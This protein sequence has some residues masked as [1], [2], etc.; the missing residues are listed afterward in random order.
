MEEMEGT[1]EEMEGTMEEMEG[2]SARKEME[3]YLFPQE[4]LT[5]GWLSSSPTIWAVNTILA[6]V[7][8]LGLFFLILSY[9]QKHRK[10]RKYQAEPWRRSNRRKKN[11]TLKVFRDC[12][13]DLEEVQDLFSLLQSRLARLSD[14]GGFHQFFRQA[15]P[16]PV[17]RGAPAGAR[18]PCRE[19]VEDA[20]PAVAPSPAHAPLTGPPQPLASTLPS[21]PMTSSISSGRTLL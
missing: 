13:Q 19:P 7:W 9:F 6:S 14:Q 17:R 15:A 2:M 18:Q 11:Q 16:G 8:G 4:F 10:S 20:A 12:L 5:D 3:N 1:M 21:G